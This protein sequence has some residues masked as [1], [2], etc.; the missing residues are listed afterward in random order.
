MLEMMESRLRWLG[1]FDVQRVLS[2]RDFMTTAE[3][4]ITNKCPSAEIVSCQWERN[5][6]PVC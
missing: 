2:V 5:R 4:T 1:E 6:Q 3:T